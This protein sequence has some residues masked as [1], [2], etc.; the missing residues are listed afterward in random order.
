MIMIDIDDK[1]GYVMTDVAIM[2]CIGLIF[3]L[4]DKPIW[5]PNLFK[6][7]AVLRSRPESEKLENQVVDLKSRSEIGSETVNNDRSSEADC[8]DRRTY[9]LISETLLPKLVRIQF[10]QLYF[11]WFK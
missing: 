10:T 1:P 5:R 9:K 3:W 7:G 11:T 4:S 8:R 2:N 6:K